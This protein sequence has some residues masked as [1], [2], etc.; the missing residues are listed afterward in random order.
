MSDS[1]DRLAYATFPLGLKAV[2]LAG[3]Y[4]AD[5]LASAYAA[6]PMEVML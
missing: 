5:G 2:M 3:R 4:S 6:P 1:T